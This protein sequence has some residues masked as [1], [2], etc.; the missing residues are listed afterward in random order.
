MKKKNGDGEEGE[1]END[2]GREQLTLQQNKYYPPRPLSNCTSD[3]YQV[4]L[5]IY[6]IFFYLNIFFKQRS[7]K[8]LDVEQQS[9]MNVVIHQL[10][11]HLNVLLYT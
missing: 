3:D 8:I 11:F 5:A 7:I 10:F 1:E 2:E 9:I 4:S 6:S